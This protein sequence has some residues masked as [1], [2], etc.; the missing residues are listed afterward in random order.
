VPCRGQTQLGT[1][2]YENRAFHV[3]LEF[4]LPVTH[5]EIYFLLLWTGLSRNKCT[6]ESE[7]QTRCPGP[8]LENVSIVTMSPRSRWRGRRGRKGGK[9]RSV[10]NQCAEA[11]N[12]G[13][14][15]SNP[16]DGNSLHTSGHAATQ[17]ISASVYSIPQMEWTYGG[18][19]GTNP[20]LAT[21]TGAPRSRRPSPRTTSSQQHLCP[22]FID[23]GRGESLSSFTIGHSGLRDPPPPPPPTGCQRCQSRSHCRGPAPRRGWDLAGRAAGT[24]AARSSGSARS[25]RALLTPARPHEAGPAAAS[26]GLAGHSSAPASLAQGSGPPA[27]RRRSGGKPGA[28][29]GGGSRAARRCPR[30]RGFAGRGEAGCVGSRAAAAAGR[31]ER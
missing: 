29:G 27:L 28:P 2:V 22:R 6:K 26:A 13:G 3:I 18:R 8:G 21:S 5:V 12:L 25:R 10:L 9:A 23:E 24:A 14:S 20:N 7:D 11:G 4:V 19:A 1:G 31:L 17:G 30:A 16:E 15:A